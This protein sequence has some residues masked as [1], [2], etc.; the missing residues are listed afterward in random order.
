MA[1][2]LRKHLKDHIDFVMYEKSP[3]LGGTWFENRYPGCACDVPSHVYQFSFAPNPDWSQFFAS[4]AE[5]QAYLKRV[6]HD[7]DLE[8]FVQYNTQVTHALWREETGTWTIE[9]N[10]QHKVESEILVN[11]GGILNNP[12]TPEIPGLSSFSGP[13][14][15][16]AAWNSRVNLEGKRIAVI[17]AGASSIQLLPQIQPLASHVDVYIRTPSWIT[18]PIG[19]EREAESA[20]PLY[21]EEEKT[22]FKQNASYYLH[23]RKGLESRFNGMFRAFVKNTTEQEALRAELTKNMKTRIQ[24]PVLQEK[25]I[26]KFEAGCRRM[27]PGEPYLG[28]LQKDNVCPVFDEISSITPQG[29]VAGGTERTCDI[30]ILATGFNTSFR[31]RFPIIGRNGIDLQQLWSET[32][33]SYMG[34]GGLEATSDYF[35]RLLR[36]VVRQGVKAFD[37]R[38]EAQQDF[39]EHTQS[40]MQKMVWTGTCRSWFKMGINGKVTALWPGSS[41]HYM[42]TLAENR[43]EDYC[44]DYFNERFSY[45]G[46]GISW[47]EDPEVDKLGVEERSSMV[48]STTVPRRGQDI[49]YYLW[50]S[51]PLESAP[52]GNIPE[53]AVETVLASYSNDWKALQE[54]PAVETIIPV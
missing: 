21:T 44:W 8:R 20:N 23:V 24:D 19:L 9:L 32:P 48:E 33:T 12:Q 27:N 22:R 41:L 39:D 7:F 5:I 46:N 38:S 54:N 43:W 28:S 42:Q 11:A 52:A 30:L 15:H 3:D 14:L 26:P 31:P 51:D 29:V 40:V 2:K 1:Y 4:S 25:L 16:T 49:S 47:I 18:P 34:T 50:A 37:V 13:Q 53:A 10:G 17:G 6:A 35:V 45:W 36:K